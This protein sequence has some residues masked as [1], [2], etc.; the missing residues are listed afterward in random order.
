MTSDDNSRGSL[1]WGWFW[2]TAVVL[3]LMCVL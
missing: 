2:M 1:S 3:Y